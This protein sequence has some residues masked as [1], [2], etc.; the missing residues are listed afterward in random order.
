M[1]ISIWW[2]RCRRWCFGRRWSWGFHRDA[3]GHL[4]SAL[5]ILKNEMGVWWLVEAEAVV[6]RVGRGPDGG[7]TWGFRVLVRRI[8]TKW[9]STEMERERENKRR[10]GRAGSSEEDDR[11]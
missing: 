7:F 8:S 1:A 3:L 2:F 11:M 5:L 10:A 9:E 4:S 6:G